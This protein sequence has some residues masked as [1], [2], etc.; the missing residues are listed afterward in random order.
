MQ[1][2]INHETPLFLLENSLKF[3]DYHFVLPHL[4]DKSPEYLDFTLRVKKIGIYIIMDNSLHE[5]GEAYDI[6]RLYH[7]IKLLQPNEFIIPDVW[8]DSTQTLVNA[9]RWTNVDL[10]DNIEKVAVVQGNSFMEAII[11]Y[12]NLKDL[13]Y[14]K[15]A[16]SY[17][18]SFYDGQTKDINKD[19]SM[20]LGRINFIS[21][22]YFKGLITDSDRI[23]ILGCQLPQEFKYYRDLPFIESVDTSNPVMSALDGVKYTNLG[24]ETKPKHN[25]NNS[26]FTNEKI[27]P[28]ILEHNVK[29]FRNFLK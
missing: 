21:H 26:F 3:N 23:H 17:G 8:Q 19:Y 20:M 25:I 22:L 7:Y 6:D 18:N 1:V 11:C 24:L 27:N 15:I 29:T 2:K 16:I 13:G 4:L 12:Q 14:R 9:K 28:N 5:L 10:G